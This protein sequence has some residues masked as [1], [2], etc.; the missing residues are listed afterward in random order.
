MP[1]RAWRIADPPRDAPVWS[2]VPYRG[3]VGSVPGGIPDGEIGGLQLAAAPPPPP[4]IER[5]ATTTQPPGPIRVFSD[6]QAA[7]LI[8]RVAPA[9]PPLARQVRISGTVKMDAVIALDGSIQSIQV[10]SGHPLLV[11]A[12][13]NAVKQ[14]RYAPTLLNG[15]PMAVVARIDVIFRLR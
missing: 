11:G 7:K 1:R 2:G 10:L 6:I 3:I 5:Q 14:W 12:A 13:I 9:Y 8:R 4:E 15:K